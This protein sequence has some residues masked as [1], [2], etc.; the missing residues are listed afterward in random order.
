MLR[1]PTTMR[2]YLQGEGRNLF[3]SEQRSPD[4]D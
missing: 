3:V 1:V 4:V 2:S